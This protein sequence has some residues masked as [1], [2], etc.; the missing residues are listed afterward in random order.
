MEKGQ[1]RKRYIS[2]RIDKKQKPALRR[3]VCVL[4]HGEEVMSSFHMDLEDLALTY[5]PA[6]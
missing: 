3:A 1:L 5:S 4:V 6:S 2:Q